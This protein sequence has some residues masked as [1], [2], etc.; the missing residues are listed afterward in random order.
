MGR[1][2]R[3]TAYIMCTVNS[4]QFVLCHV[5]VEVLPVYSI[6]P[7]SDASPGILVAHLGIIDPSRTGAKG[8]PRA[9][10]AC[11]FH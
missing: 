3:S 9:M 6:S 2:L 8:N 4:Q 5:F 11:L 7:C 10:T 1:P